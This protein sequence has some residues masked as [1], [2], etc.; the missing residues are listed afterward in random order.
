MTPDKIAEV[1]Q[2]RNAG[3]LSPAAAYLML[4]LGEVDTDTA[5]KLAAGVLE[6]ADA[7]VIHTFSVTAVTQTGTVNVLNN[8]ITSIDK[9]IG[10]TDF[11]KGQLPKNSYLAVSRVILDYSAAAASYAP[12]TSVFSPAKFDIAGA[13]RH[14]AGILNGKLIVY[15]NN[16]PLFEMPVDSL[17]LNGRE[18]TGAETVRELAV[19]KIIPGGTDIKI[20]LIM[21]GATG[22]TSGHFHHFKVRFQGAITKSAPGK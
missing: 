9:A 2:L 8:N 21:A 22:G 20:E 16:K 15:S 5:A 19:P 7:E 6:I 14:P 10:V 17:V 13:A 3:L 1:V 12:L 4:K 11:D 18:F